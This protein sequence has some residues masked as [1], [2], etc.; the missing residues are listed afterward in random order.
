MVFWICLA[1]VVLALGVLL[2]LALE[3]RAKQQRLSRTL[4]TAQ[5][6]VDQANAIR[7]ALQPAAPARPEE[8]V[9]TGAAPVPVPAD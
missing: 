9:G 1:L 7:A 5:V 6:Q 3:L 2:T 8:R 4:Q